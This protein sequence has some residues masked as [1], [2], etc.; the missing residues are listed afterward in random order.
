M[1]VN[2]SNCNK[3]TGRTCKH[4][5]ARPGSKQTHVT[6]HLIYLQ[7]A[8][9]PRATATI[10]FFYK[11]VTSADRNTFYKTNSAKFNKIFCFSNEVSDYPDIANKILFYI[12]CQ[13]TLIFQLRAT[14]RTCTETPGKKPKL[15]VYFLLLISV[16]STTHTVISVFSLIRASSPITLRKQRPWQIL[17][18]HRRQSQ[19][20]QVQPKSD[21][22]DFTVWSGPL[23]PRWW[24]SNSP[25]RK[26][27]LG[28]LR[29]GHLLKSTMSNSA[30]CC[31]GL[32]LQTLTWDYAPPLVNHHHCKP[33]ECRD[34]DNSNRVTHCQPAFYYSCA[35]IIHMVDKVVVTAATSAEI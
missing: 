2:R 32:Q 19:P 13:V 33:P 22:L 6:C 1:G 23:Q 14:N 34:S 24:S 8:Y 7:V 25:S 29:S 21:Q 18:L 16:S 17:P 20:R 35:G 26:N 12:Y 30:H 11:C 3:L 4:H 5:T 27:S 15:P 31:P 28:A 9:N 10:H